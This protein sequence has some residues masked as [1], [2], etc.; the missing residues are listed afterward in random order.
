V[1]TNLL[2]RISGGSGLPM[3][4]QL[5]MA[6]RLGEILVSQISKERSKE[7]VKSNVPAIM[8]EAQVGIEI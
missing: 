2:D 1:R 4:C 5:G 8:T 6:R 3:R 7:V